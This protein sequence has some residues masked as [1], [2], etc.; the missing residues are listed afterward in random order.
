VIEA[1]VRTSAAT[2]SDGLGG[3]LLSIH[4]EHADFV[5]LTLQRVGVAPADIEDCLQEVFIVVHQRLGSF[6]GSSRMTTWLYGICIRVASAYR[7]RSY[8]RRERTGEE[9]QEAIDEGESPE[10]AASRAEAQ[11]RLRHVLDEMDIEKRALFVMFEID[12]VS[13]EEIAEIL[14]IPIG[15]VYSRLHSARKEFESA[16]RRLEARDKSR[17]SWRRWGQS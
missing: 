11:D 17:L 5:W 16:L 14:G 3:D 9:V 7:R 8:R 15:T 10:L 6:D 1:S 12:E 13:C 2:A 4:A